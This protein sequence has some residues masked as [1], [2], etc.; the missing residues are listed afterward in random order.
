MNKFLILMLVLVCIP[1]L[2]VA[3]KLA[4]LPQLGEPVGLELDGNEVYVYDGVTVLVYDKKDFRLLR[5]FG[6]AGE[7]PGEIV[8][9]GEHHPLMKIEGEHVIVNNPNKMITFSKNGDLVKEKVFHML[10]AQ[11]VNLGDNFA[12]LRVGIGDAKGKQAFKVAIFDKD[13]KQ[14]KELYS[15]ERKSAMKT[16]KIII[17]TSFIYIRSTGD[18]LYVF[19]QTKGFH[20]DTYDKDGAPGKPITVPYEPVK[21][22]KTYQD[23]TMAWLKKQKFYRDL[24]PMVKTMFAFPEYLPVM[25]TFLVKNGKIYVQTY[26]EKDNLSEFYILDLNGKVLR[27]VFLPVDLSWRYQASPHALFTFKDNQCYY[28]SENIDKEVWE[29]HRVPI[30]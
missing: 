28:L 18:R 22:S 4:E 29:L 27:H 9:S 15:R 10:V 13:M 20:I 21:V 19:D 16:G 12:V 24:P 2:G 7:G 1:I 11:T 6:K 30:K 3:E 26:K 5:K 23:D 14:L 17:P 8:P 25:K